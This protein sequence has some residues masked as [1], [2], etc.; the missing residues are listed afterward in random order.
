[1]GQ[2]FRAGPHT[3]SSAHCSHGI[4]R[5]YGR[6]MDILRRIDVQARA[7]VT[8]SLADSL[9]SRVANLTADIA[10]LQMQQTDL[11]SAQTYQVDTL[12]MA[13]CSDCKSQAGTPQNVRCH[14]QGH[15]AYAC[16]DCGHR[17]LMNG[18][19]GCAG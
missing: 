6:Q 12:Q 17:S 19:L 5:A 16:V 9:R 8:H 18:F 2:T 1:M 4:K 3:C 7:D 15:A 11:L 10:A 13:N 14:R